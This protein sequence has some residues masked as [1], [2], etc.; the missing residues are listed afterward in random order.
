MSKEARHRIHGDELRAELERVLKQRVKIL[1]RRLSAYSSSYTVENLDVTLA[2]GKKLRLVLKDVSPSSVLATAQQVRPHFLYHPAREI[3]VYQK[4]LNPARVG[5]A[6]C[7]GAVNSAELE[8]HWLFL[9]RVEGRLLWQVGDLAQWDAT[10]RWLGELHSRLAGKKFSTA[11]TL[12]RYDEK[13]F[14][15]WIGRAEKFLKKR[16]VAELRQ[17]ARLAKNYHRVVK[18]LVALPQSF[19][20]GE[21][22]ASNVIMRAGA[23]AHAIC[24]IDWEL[25]GIGS[26]ALDLA[27]LTAGEWSDVEK[28]RFVTAYHEGL[29]SLRAPSVDELLESMELCQLHLSV[30]MLGW[31]EDWAPPEKHAQNWLR[32][33]LRLGAKYGFI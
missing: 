21:C 19:I 6:Q 10:A 9:E 4:I 29:S 1:R 7:V 5:T 8:R 25:A 3:E 11:K 31:A 23:P 27:A 22:Y 2:R 16:R 20:H 17:F 24:V 14:A 32:T 33:A 28:L 26:G 30:Q 13:F 12:L 15:V 18:K